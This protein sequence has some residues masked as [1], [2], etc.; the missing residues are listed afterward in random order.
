VNE[1]AHIT[2]WTLALTEPPELPD[3]QYSLPLAE[4][5][6]AMFDSTVLALL[7]GDAI[8]VRVPVVGHWW[9]ILASGARAPLPVAVDGLNRAG[10][11]RVVRPLR[12]AAERARA[13]AR[14]A[15]ALEDSEGDAEERL[16]TRTDF[17]LV[18]VRG[19]KHTWLGIQR[20]KRR[21]LVRMESG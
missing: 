2:V 20:R 16:T 15:A 6:G 9:R 18:L 3:D 14:A 1:N 11:S 4:L 8:L 17:I 13:A 10:P 12:D 7:A 5:V 21:A 19:S